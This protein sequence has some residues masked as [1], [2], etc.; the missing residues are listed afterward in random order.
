MPQISALSSSITSRTVEVEKASA[1]GQKFVQAVG[2]LAFC[3]VLAVMTA[4]STQGPLKPSSGA[5]SEGA[6]KESA[7]ETTA[8]KRV[9]KFGLALGGGAARGFAHVGVIQVLEEAGLKPDFVVGTSAGSLVAAFYAS[10]KNG[11]QLQQLSE[12]MD[13]ATITDWT[14]P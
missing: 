11:A 6:V 12:T 3:A 5:A 9:P 10:G 7:P 13:E 8:V 1:F 14:M 4:C 2:K